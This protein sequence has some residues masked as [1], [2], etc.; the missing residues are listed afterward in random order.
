MDT[1]LVLDRILVFAA[2]RMYTLK[3]TLP[4]L[5][6]CLPYDAPCTLRHVIRRLVPKKDLGS[7]GRL[8]VLRMLELPLSRQSIEEIAHGAAHA[9]NIHV[10]E[11]AHAQLPSG[12]HLFEVRYPGHSMSA[13]FSIAY[14]AIEHAHIPLLDWAIRN[15]PLPV[16]DWLR[17]YATTHSCTFEFKAFFGDLQPAPSTRHVAMLDCDNG[18]LLVDWFRAYC[19]ETGRTFRRWW[20]EN[21]VEQI[22]MAR[23]S[24]LLTAEF[25]DT[26]C[27]QGHSA[28]LDW[29]WDLCTDLASDIELSP[30]WRPRCPFHWLNVI[31]WWEAKV[32]SGKVDAAIFEHP[33]M[34]DADST[35]LD[36]FFESPSPQT[37][38]PMMSPGALDWYWAHRDR[39]GLEMRLS[40]QVLSELVTCKHLDLLHWYLDHCTIESPLPILTLHQIADLVSRGHA[41]LVEQHWQL[42]SGRADIVFDCT[43]QIDASNSA[44]V[45]AQPVVLDYL[46]EYCTR[47]GVRCPLFYDPKSAMQAKADELAEVVRWWDAMHRVH[48]TAFPSAEDFLTFISREEAEWDEILA[49]FS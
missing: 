9:G 11:W 22:G 7:M 2:H 31:Q 20:W 19:A 30:E 44:S 3:D 25:L 47:A 10:L 4:L 41:M 21:V 46:W 40:P 16:L 27:E 49:M 8:G 37:Y 14:P 33:P 35:R 43:E 17:V 32:A 23:A 13:F 1:T 15:G 29:H 24:E 48:G 39:F 6:V 45:I 34:K 12:V 28:N 36:V 5:S 42:S 38:G 26:M 18:R